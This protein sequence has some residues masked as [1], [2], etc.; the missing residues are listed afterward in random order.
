LLA[1]LLAFPAGKWLFRRWRRK[2][3]VPDVAIVGAW[4]ELMDRYVDAVVEVPVGLTRAETADVLDRPA[5]VAVAAIVDR[6]V[7]AE[8][9][10]THQA[11][12]A[13]WQVLDDER[14]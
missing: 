8:H 11:S 6:A 3:V 1:P 2:A 10:P 13:L 7:F 4:A 5:A 12:E 9:P 14:R